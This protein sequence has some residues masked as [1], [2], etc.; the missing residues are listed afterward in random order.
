MTTSGRGPV[1]IIDDDPDIRDALDA[2]LESDGYT[3]AVA[4]NGLEA[5]GQLAAGLR[6]CLILLDLTMPCMNGA[7]FRRI[8]ATDPALS[9]IP[10]VV[11]SAAPSLTQTAAALGACGHVGKPIELQVLLAVVQRC[12]GIQTS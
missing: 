1:L 2:A 6:P 5:L 4:A 8:Q 7:Q 11:M 10:V 9:S 3:V 12:S